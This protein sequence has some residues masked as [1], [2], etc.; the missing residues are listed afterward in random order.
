MRFK[1][2]RYPKW[3]IWFNI[4]EPISWINFTIRVGNWRKNF[5]IYRKV[6]VQ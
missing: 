2:V 5:A 1:L 3:G 6:K 4:I